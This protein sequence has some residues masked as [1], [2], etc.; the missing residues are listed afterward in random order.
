[1]VAEARLFSHIAPLLMR[2]KTLQRVFD[3]KMRMN[4]S[5]LSP[6]DW[7]GSFTSS[8]A[9][10]A[11]VASRRMFAYRHVRAGH[12]LPPWVLK[13]AVIDEHGGELPLSAVL[14]PRTIEV[15]VFG[16]CS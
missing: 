1:M 13:A 7:V 2:S 15:L 3:A 5:S 12:R 14:A 6:E 9:A 16:S 4:T 10:E 8:E 11:I